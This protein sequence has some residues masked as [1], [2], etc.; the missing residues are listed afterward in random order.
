MKPLAALAISISILLAQ[1]ERPASKSVTAVRNWSLGE[2][3]RVA[4]EIS[5]EFEFRTDRLHN[6]ERV[7]FDIVGARPSFEGKRA[8][9]QTFEDDMLVRGVRV[10]ETTPGVTRIVLDLAADVEVTTSRLANPTRL[11][12]EARATK[13]AP[14][15]PT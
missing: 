11:M 9:R 1:G 12:I 15:V 2:I 6:P 5:G 8:F 3:T 4:V 7:Y 13:S 14:V 10:A